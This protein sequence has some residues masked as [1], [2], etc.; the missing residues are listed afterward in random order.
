MAKAGNH[1]A[2]GKEMTNK[3]NQ[4]DNNGNRTGLWKDYDENGKLEET[5]K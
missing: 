5:E 2:G 3:I 4:T 1:K